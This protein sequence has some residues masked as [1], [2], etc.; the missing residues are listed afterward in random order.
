MFIGP[1]DDLRNIPRGK[2]LALSLPGGLEAR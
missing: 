2:I 1:A